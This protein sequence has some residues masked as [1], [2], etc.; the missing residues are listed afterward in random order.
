MDFF[1]I[2]LGFSATFLVTYIIIISKNFH[3]KFT[4]DYL[5]GAQKFHSLPTPR[6]GG[7]SILSGF[8]VVYPFLNNDI[9]ILWGILGISSL[10][11]FI[12]GI[13]EDIS[14]SVSPRIRLLITFVSSFMFIILSNYTLKS[15]GIIGVD[16]I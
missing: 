14:G 11:T 9:K 5:K 8:F 2:F 7:L 15:I 16:F 6:V 12:I 1:Q 13:I 10:P 4:F 3:G